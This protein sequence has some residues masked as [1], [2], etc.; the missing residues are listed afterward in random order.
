MA[1]AGKK[2]FDRNDSWRSSEFKVINQ[3]YLI[4]YFKHA[5][6]A[7]GNY[8]QITKGKQYYE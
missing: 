5:Q 2:E 6:W 3:K 7:K 1:D 4:N 8:G